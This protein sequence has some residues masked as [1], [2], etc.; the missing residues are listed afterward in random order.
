MSG[1]RIHETFPDI[2]SPE[3]LS[4]HLLGGGQIH[5]Q[6]NGRGREHVADVVEPVADVVGRKLI[7]RTQVEAEQV[8]NG[9]VVLG[10]IEATD[11]DSPGTAVV[12]E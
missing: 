6:Q 3:R 9:V 10:A 8:A 2:R 7:R 12:R 5:F 4:D 1:R 11:G